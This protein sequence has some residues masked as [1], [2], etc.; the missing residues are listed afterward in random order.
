MSEKNMFS[1]PA[2]KKIFENYGPGNRHIQF[3]LDYEEWL[4]TYT[5]PELFTC[6]KCEIKFTSKE[7][8]LKH[9]TKCKN[10]I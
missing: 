7:Y 2:C 3:C 6:D 5:P 10:K 8:L 1:C 4:K 9:E